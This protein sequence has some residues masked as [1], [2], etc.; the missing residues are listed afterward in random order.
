[1]TSCAPLRAMCGYYEKYT[2]TKTY[3]DKTYFYNCD[4]IV[5]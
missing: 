5:T 2:G 4:P 3:R 1:M